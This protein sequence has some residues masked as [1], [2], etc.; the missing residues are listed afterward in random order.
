MQKTLNFFTW[1]KA[2]KLEYI[3]VTR[4][5]KSYIATYVSE[6]INRQGKL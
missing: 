4:N 5:G 1:V 3:R 2:T 6:K